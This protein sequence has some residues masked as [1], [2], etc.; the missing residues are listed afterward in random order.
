MSPPC[1]STEQA[2]AG[3]PE[4]D[5]DI[6]LDDQLNL[7]VFQTEAQVAMLRHMPALGLSSA[8]AL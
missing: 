5:T 6:D 4:P 3:E 2:T 7:S 1:S 8:L